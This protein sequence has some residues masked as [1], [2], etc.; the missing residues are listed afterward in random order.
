M[1]TKV[2][3]A[4]KNIEKTQESTAKVAQIKIRGN[5]PKPGELQEE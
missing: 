2:I 3:A 4:Q 1:A 5:S